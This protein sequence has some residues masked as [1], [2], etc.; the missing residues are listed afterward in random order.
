M[1]IAQYSQPARE[2]QMVC[3]HPSQIIALQKHITDLQS[4]QFLPPQCG[5]TT[6]T[7]QIQPQPKKTRRSSQD[8]PNPGDRRETSTGTRGDAQNSTAILRGNA[9]FEDAVSECAFLSGTASPNSLQ[10]TQR[11]TAK[12]SHLPRVYQHRAMTTA[13]VDSISQDGQMSYAL[14]ISGRTVQDAVSIH[15]S[16]RD[17]LVPESTTCAEHQDDRAVRATSLLTPPGSRCWKSRYGGHLRT[18]DEGNFTKDE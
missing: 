3:N 16:H 5:H 10:G 6:I 8:S 14:E 7:Q 1:G 9:Q 15:P 4:Q 12:I 13:R 2:V 18:Q 11:Y 17:R